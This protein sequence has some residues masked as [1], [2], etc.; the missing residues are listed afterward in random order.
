MQSSPS[1]GG[2]H[3]SSIA[4]SPRIG[5]PLSQQGD[6]SPVASPGG[7]GVY[8]P[9]PPI[10][11]TSPQ[12][13]RVVTSPLGYGGGD[14]TV[15]VV[16]IRPGTPGVGT[17]GAVMQTRFI[18][19]Q[20]EQAQLQQQQQLRMRLQ[21]QSPQGPGFPQKP[22]TPSPLN[23]PP[24]QQQQ[25]QQY[26]QRQLQ[27]QVYLQQQ[28]H[29]QQ[30]QPPID[31]GLAHSHRTMQ[32]IQQRQLILKQQQQS[33]SVS[34]A[35]HQPAALTPQQHQLMVQQQQQLHKQQVARLQQQQQG[36][37]AP[38]SS[39]MMPQSPLQHQQMMSPHH[40]S[41]PAS[42][43][44]PR[45]PMVV[46]G[47]QQQQPPSS[48]MQM[49][50]G[51]TSPMMTMMPSPMG[52][53]RPPSVANLSSPA[54]PE[55]PVSVE[56]PGTPRT[57]YSSQ[58]HSS[59]DDQQQQHVYTSISSIS[60]STTPTTN[61]SS[62]TSGGGGN[63]NN[64]S[65]P[66]PFPPC[67]GRFGSFKFGLRG[68]APP[69]WPGN[70]Y[71]I[72][73]AR[74]PATTEEPTSSSV[75]QSTTVTSSN[76]SV[77]PVPSMSVINIT[78]PG[79]LKLKKESH[80]SKV[81][82]LKKNS[83][84][85]SNMALL[86]A[87]GAAGGSGLM[88]RVQS[89]V[90]V[91]YNE[92]D[93]SSSTPPV[94]PPPSVSG[95]NRFLPKTSGK[96]IPEKPPTPTTITVSEPVREIVTVEFASSSS[97]GKQQVEEIDYDDDN[98][99]NLV[100]TEVTLSDAAQ[101]NDGDEMAVIETFSQSDL[102]DVMSS[103]LESHQIADDFIFFDMPSGDQYSDKEDGDEDYSRELED[104]VESKDNTHIIN[105][106]IQSPTSSEEEL[107]LQGKTKQV[108][109][110]LVQG[111]SAEHLLSVTDTPDSPEPEEMN[112]DPPDSP[113]TTEE[114]LTPFGDTQIVIIDQP[115]TSK[116]LEEQISTKEDFEELIDEG[117]RKEKLVVKPKPLSQTYS[118]PAN[119]FNFNP[120]Q[121]VKTITTT[122][123]SG[124]IIT[125]TI[126]R[127][128][129]SVIPGK[130][131]PQPPKISLIRSPNTV[132]ISKARSDLVMQTPQG[133]KLRT[134]PNLVPTSTPAITIVRASN[135][136]IAQ[137]LQTSR[138]TAPVISASAINNLPNVKFIS[139]QEMTLPNKIFEDDSVSPDSSNNEEDKKSD[140][141]DTPTKVLEV[142][143]PLV[144]PE[145]TMTNVKVVNI[146]TKIP[147]I[148]KPEIIKPSPVITT[149][150]AVI[151]HPPPELKMTAQIIDDSPPTI[152]S[153][154]DVDA[155]DCGSTDDTKSVV[156]S[157]P[158]PTPSQEQY[159]TNLS[160]QELENDRREG[161]RVGG[162][163][164]SFED[165]LDMIEN[166]A[167]ATESSIRESL[168]AK[169][170]LIKQEL[171]NENDGV[172]E[173]EKVPLILSQVPILVTSTEIPASAITL[174][175]SN[176]LSVIPQLS[177]LSQ[178]TELTTNISNVSQQLRTLLSNLQTTSSTTTNVIESVVR[179]SVNKEKTD[180][181]P[182]KLI[183]VTPQMAPNVSLFTTVVTTS[184][185][186][187]V[188]MPNKPKVVLV[189]STTSPPLCSVV[190][191]TLPTP[192]ITAVVT[193]VASQHPALSSLVAAGR[194]PVIDHPK[195][196]PLS[197]T[198]PVVTPP[199]IA[200]SIPATLTTISSPA[201]SNISS[202]NFLGSVS[203]VSSS[204]P[205][206]QRKASL[207]L[208]AMLQS[209]PAATIPQTSPGTI[210]T[211]SI[212]C[213]SASITKASFSPGLAQAQPHVTVTTPLSQM[214]AVTTSI[215]N[216]SSPSAFVAKSTIA[217][218]NLLHSQ[219]TKSPVVRT[220]KP[221]EEK[222]ELLIPKI[223][224]MDTQDCPIT[225]S[226]LLKTHDSSNKFSLCGPQNRMED[227]QNVLLKQLLQNTACATSSQSAII[228]SEVLTTT[229]PATAPNLP[230]VP[231]LEA[232]LARPVPPIATSLLPPVLQQS[233]HYSK[234]VTRA[235]IMS[236]ETSFVSKPVTPCT[237]PA[238]TIPPPIVTAAIVAVSSAAP[239]TPVSQ[240]QAQQSH[241]QLQLQQQPQQHQQL[242][243]QPI[244][245]QQY[246]H[247][248]QAPQ[249]FPQQPVTIQPPQVLPH[250]Q[251]HIDIK[252]C[253]PPS[254][255]PSRDEILS[256]PTPRSS[257]SQDSSLQTPPLVIK[258]EVILPTP[259]QSP[260]F[261]PQEVKKEFIDDTS[262]HS[263]VSDHSKS[264]LPVKEELDL[265]LDAE[266]LLQEKE[267]A[268]KQKRRQYQAK[269]RQNQIMKENA[270]A[271]AGLNIAIGASATTQPKKRPRKTSKLDEDYDSYIESVLNQIRQL[272]P[273]NVSEPILTRNFLAVPLSGS[274]DLSK[275]SLEDFDPRIGDLEGKY[276]DAIV[277]DYTDYY[278][279]K[280]YGD[281]DALPEKPP[282]STQRGF[283][284]Q[285]FPLI[286]FEENRRFD[287]FAR[288]DTPDSIVSCS[289]PE[290]S[291]DEQQK[292]ANNNRFPGLGLIH[293]DDDDDE[294]DTEG[295]TPQITGNRDRL[296][297]VV[298]I[299]TPIPIRL[300]PATQQLK[301][302]TTDLGKE[303]LEADLSKQRAKN[304]ATP[305]KDNAGNV[306]VTLTLTSSAAEDIMG[307][308]RDLAN[309]LQIPAPTTYQ[310]VERTTSPPSQKL[311]L[312][313][314]KGKDGKEGAPID[315]QSILN[316]AAKFC[317]HCD[318]VILNN[319]IR[320][321]FS[322]LPFLSK[323]LATEGDELYF[324]SSTCYMQF[325]LMHRSPSIPEDKAAAIVD[326]ICQ[327]DPNDPS[328]TTSAIAPAILD[329][330]RMDKLDILL[331]RGGSQGLFKDLPTVGFDLK[332]ETS[333]GGVKLGSR[334][335][336]M[337]HAE[338]AKAGKPK[339]LKG[340]RYKIYTMDCLQPATK[341]KRA[342]DKE[343]M[344]MMYRLRITVMPTKIPEDSR[345][346]M[347]CHNLSDAVAD[348]AGR[349]LNYDADRWIHLNC[350][351]WSDGV[352]ETVN[353]ALMNI[354]TALKHSLNG[355]C[356]HCERTGATVRCFK[357]R[358][359][360]VYHLGCAVK[361]GCTFYK[362]KSVYC[363]VHVPKG[364]KE[365]ELTTLSVSRRVYVDRDENSQVATVM[366]HSDLNHLLR[367]GS[368][369]F[370]SVGQLLPHQLPH[371]HT[372]N[373]I[374]PIGYKIIRFYWSMRR[375]N[376]RCRYICS[377][378]EVH[379]KPE[380]RVLVQEPGEEDVEFRANS[381]KAV[382]LNILEPMATL[383][384]E[385][386]SVR[387][388]PRYVSGEDL[389]GLTEPAVVRVLES[390]PG[391]E[392]LSDYKFKY[393]RN[394]LLELPLAI[395]PSGAAR[396]EAKLRN[397]LHWK[398]PH[399]QRTTG[400]SGSPGAT[401]PTPGATG[402]AGGSGSNIRSAFSSGPS[403]SSGN[404]S[405]GASAS[406]CGNGL[407]S[408][409]LGE[410]IGPY[411]KQFVHSK[412]SQYKKM[413]LEWRNN[414]F[415]ARSKIQG[416]GLYAA[417]DLEKHTMVIEYIGELIRAELAEMRERKYE[418]RNRGI[419]MFRL[420]EDRVVDASE[421]GGLARYINHSCNPNCVAEIVEVERDLR[422]IIFA[423]R[424]I[425]RGEELAYDYKFDIEDDQH[426]IS[427][428]CGAPNCRKWMN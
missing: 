273:L 339:S 209:H 5:T 221:E 378:H 150:S 334:L 62:S 43:M 389:F 354:P 362:N 181:P 360:S 237:S 96:R 122:G 184:Q 8:L 3:T 41:Q 178:P 296:S 9:P 257:C 213:S 199:V 393:G 372:P 414:V 294:V 74:P 77:G 255:T 4:S 95:L 105:V 56:N 262:Q 397:Q 164:E 316:G 421:S 104:I 229:P 58:D 333:M 342:T 275:L 331:N 260:I 346:C 383:R 39:P 404:S 345:R 7:V 427:C 215:L 254:R 412:S 231:N 246:H 146:E 165:V 363:S 305:L 20:L 413:K 75:N 394:P 198:V 401:T 225:T 66:I 241:S 425:L 118:T 243:Q 2:T 210:T 159:L 127:P 369:I 73:P 426:K 112:V 78:H 353:G 149:P 344:E 197:N 274:G 142:P 242:M 154:S 82:I 35:T 349:L 411:S 390:L 60:T 148:S 295:I 59:M 162:E 222:K 368:L 203:T 288:D 182:P 324:C 206:Q 91:D 51:V 156:I 330:Q 405:M 88:R 65:T 49:Q 61:V 420:D 68:G 115:G 301:D 23:S 55:R 227:S 312:Y 140:D 151:H 235:P 194:K 271:V 261:H 176:R 46:G 297:P 121:V 270:A 228:K 54:M 144:K 402:S 309:I 19:P 120:K 291:L 218:S 247:Q 336:D 28:Q 385:G 302:F 38:P 161:N 76:S 83:P 13:R 201:C 10:R 207:S 37:Q 133:L 236:R 341:F 230:L 232:Q 384:R 63:P 328:S 44:P 173:P 87:Q 358:C 145:I 131:V 313:R 366:H 106:A 22:G 266:R 175:T 193:S 307:V 200:T 418:A 109:M 85:R 265:I 167:G 267:E 290:P 204:Q 116:S 392:T 143:P 379:T 152:A 158:S 17:A 278:D 244:I 376:K 284:D 359:G 357:T 381:C 343:I 45:S 166:Y 69:M 249:V 185:P 89:L 318:V 250:Q 168:E 34:G 134:M 136:Q 329:K 163:F 224:P 196:A 323:E 155:M 238:V 67:F 72:R 172:K 174:T 216:I 233:E 256:P 303:N 387:I 47:Y 350:G 322:E 317:R 391:I 80:R 280:P 169:D 268:K 107:I 139:H 287:Q 388:F 355:V 361:D 129:V 364:E 141:P 208:N 356:A 108:S 189:T 408:S 371:F 234:I 101:Q 90:S 93:D 258:K 289:S 123:P 277:P 299:I 31:E 282:A 27:Q 214:A 283:Y 314:T 219:L 259:L 423:K 252:K 325:A 321:R 399:T 375:L 248:P 192:A 132:T 226:A 279:T 14:G 352:Y 21:Q 71:T 367:V 251:L 320:K 94:T 26:I 276:G 98:D 370:L 205:Q 25:Q 245:Q 308:L 327:K 6:N 285:E 407:G 113:E 48:P 422:I 332:R 110:D 119:V 269:R 306:T 298:P 281:L 99:N 415:L 64:P 102:A 138:S 111:L 125:T 263:E 395:N 239:P 338:D 386:G 410:S 135:S 377:I 286:R 419:Y 186:V 217:T 42:P 253:A 272:P 157:I 52:H 33:Q 315:I 81:T 50:G 84:A 211:A 409:S 382:W 137:I 374:F 264:D 117:S 30:Q 212:L 351:L 240:Q 180:P 130:V 417:R 29:Q 406:L 428:M 40:I 340:T 86:A 114:P 103:P 220:P 177:P 188:F 373:Y 183:P 365:N 92:F 11:M 97:A 398:R 347:F 187:N 171:E 12:H 1:G 170:T 191:S 100:S 310:I 195:L 300:K 380:F 126:V 124:N 292:P 16:G 32:L 319:M 337:K 400:N 79:G 160:L 70:T 36:Q 15:G 304:N 53:R 335:G 416:L 179:N 147:L 153:N 223:E 348:G 18:R 326:H 57:P 190:S 396:T 128:S 24:P 311:G 403:G 424:R 202:S 293:E